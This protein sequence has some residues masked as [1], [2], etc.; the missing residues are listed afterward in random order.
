MIHAAYIDLAVLLVLLLIAEPF[1]LQNN[2]RVFSPTTIFALS[3]GGL[4]V[5][6]FWA[7]DN[8]VGEGMGRFL[9][10][11]EASIAINAIRKFLYTYAFAFLMCI[12]SVKLVKATPLAIQEIHVVHRYLPYVLVAAVGIKVLALGTGVGFS[13]LAIVHRAVSPRDFTYI[14]EGVGPINY[15]DRGFYIVSLLMAAVNLNT[16]RR[17]ILARVLLLFAV[18]LVLAGGRKAAISSV[19]ILCV[20]IWQ[21]CWEDISLA[22]RAVLCVAILA[23]VLA[24]LTLSFS[25]H[26]SPGEHGTLSEGAEKLAEYQQEAYFLP[27]V[28]KQYPWKIDYPL[29]ILYDTAYNPIPRA[30]WPDKPFGGTWFRYFGPDFA[31]ESLATGSTCT[32]GCL[33]EAHMMFGWAGPYVYGFVWGVLMCRMYRVLLGGRT[34]FSLLAV[35][36]LTFFTYLI[37]RTGFFD[38]TAWAV[39]IT[40]GTGY[41][42]LFLARQ[43]NQVSARSAAR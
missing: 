6:P 10:E 30:L 16:T 3:I 18:L 2:Y 11:D 37:C 36:F 26:Y 40:L 29:Q 31:P 39:I 12:R 15:L 8:G 22:K 17:K 43:S 34:A 25:L 14:G 28:I 32:C 38:A 9:T 5:F 1:I 42:I 20:V 23:T 19:I 35:S 13:P 21:K 24:A 41:G 27:L 33:A 7:V 4:Y